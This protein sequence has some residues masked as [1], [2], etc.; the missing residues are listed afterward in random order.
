MAGSVARWET[1]CSRVEDSVATQDTAWSRLEDPA[2]H[3]APFS[4]FLTCGGNGLD[5]LYTIVYIR[6]GCCSLI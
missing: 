2:S 1:T 6:R 4:S 3:A 5:S